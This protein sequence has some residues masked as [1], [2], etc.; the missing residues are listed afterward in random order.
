MKHF[1]LV[2]TLF[3][4]SCG[5]GID[6]LPCER[7]DFGVVDIV[8][9]TS[10]IHY[11]VYCEIVEGQEGCDTSEL[12]I[13]Y[14]YMRGAVRLRLHPGNYQIL[15]RYL[16][17][18]KEVDQVWEMEIHRCKNIKFLIEKEQISLGDQPYHH[19]AVKANITERNSVIPEGLEK[20]SECN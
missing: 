9:A 2:A 11:A 7:Y 12:I 16:K 13:I 19:L 15:I 20:N 3:L 5:K 10:R 8:N 1:I 6:T 14:P 18:G 4:F 17:D